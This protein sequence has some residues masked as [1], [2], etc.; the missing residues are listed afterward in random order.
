MGEA[1]LAKGDLHEAEAAVLQGLRFVTASEAT[2]KAKLLFLAADL[3]E[4]QKSYDDATVKW[5][6][7]ESFTT[8]Q[9][10]AQGFPAS[11]TER[12]KALETWKKVSLD[13]AAVKAR[14]DKRL[15]EADESVR[16]SSQ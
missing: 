10:A 8:E 16:K 5:T 2:L 1:Q 4:R 14:I 3:R 15:K 12:K 6:D 7:Y 13:S 11:A 9:K